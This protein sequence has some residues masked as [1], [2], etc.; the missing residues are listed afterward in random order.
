MTEQK[1]A[2]KKVTP[3][4]YMGFWKDVFLKSLERYTPAKCAELANEA[5]DKI[6]DK[7]E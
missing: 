6:Q 5:V 7:F 1:K 4:Q 2:T 3:Q